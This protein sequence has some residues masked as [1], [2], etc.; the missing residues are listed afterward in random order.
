MTMATGVVALSGCLAVKAV[1]AP[2]KLAAVTVI[3]VSETTG[4]AV[5]GTGRVTRAAL[6]TSTKLTA[7]SIEALGQLSTPGLVTFLDVNQGAVLRVPW[8][9]GMNV[10]LGSQLAQVEFARRALAIVR[11]GRLVHQVARARSDAGRFQ[12]LAGDV[13]R[14]ASP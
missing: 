13:V 9:Q 12:V 4:A 5:V 11:A 10:A 1:T 7:E 8:Q 6:N 14:L 2:V 3:T